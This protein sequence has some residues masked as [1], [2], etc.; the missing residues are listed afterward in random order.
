VARGRP[1][2][3]SAAGP[4]PQQ[5]A[6][7]RSRCNPRTGAAIGR[8]TAPWSH[9]GSA[10]AGRRPVP[11]RPPPTIGH[12]GR[13]QPALVA[14]AVSWPRGGRQ[15]ALLPLSP[16]PSAPSTQTER[17]EAAAVAAASDRPS[18]E[19]GSWLCVGVGRWWRGGG[20]LVPGPLG[21]ACL[22]ACSRNP[23]QRTRIS[24][25]AHDLHPAYSAA[26]P[27][28]ARITR[29]PRPQRQHDGPQAGCGRPRPAAQRGPRQGLRR[30]GRARSGVRRRR[31]NHPGTAGAGARGGG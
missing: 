26:P 22:E 24:P 17:T 25:R 14:A 20:S 10:P 29:S 12:V 21:A 5:P 9:A 11:L 6:P 7:S 2:A 4:P 23:R 1:P 30:G 15:E 13:A 8:R 3:A 19:A 31:P 18:S 27:C 16:P 28:R